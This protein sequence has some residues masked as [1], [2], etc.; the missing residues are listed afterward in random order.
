MNR[1]NE[2][3]D[4]TEKHPRQRLHTMSDKAQRHRSTGT[5][6]IVDESG[7]ARIGPTPERLAQANG[8]D[9]HAIEQ[10]TTEVKDPDRDILR[11]ATTVRLLD[12]D[13]LALLFS[14]KI[15]TQAQYACGLEYLHH[16]H[17]SGLASA[18][19]PNLLQDRVDGGQHKPEPERK[20]WHL[21]K[22]S[23]MVRDL[24]EIHSSVLTACILHGASLAAYGTAQGPYGR[25]R[26]N[27]DWAQISF[28]NALRQLEINLLG[29]PRCAVHDGMQ[30]AE[31]LAPPPR[32]RAAHAKAK[33][34]R[35]RGR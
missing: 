32:P 25:D 9:D 14:R 24:G 26:E 23:K 22:W 15:I 18:G 21:N 3:N 27:R 17:E 12:G 29:A 20:M 11:R 1:G 10:I 31:A 16:W 4:G 5:P 13:P 28:V 34:G 30:Q 2:R 19:V 35:W 33:A 7:Q 8:S 6:I